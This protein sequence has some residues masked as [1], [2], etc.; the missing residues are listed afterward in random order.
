MSD[1]PEDKSE[2]KR[3]VPRAKRVT[4][5]REFSSVEELVR[6]YVS[7]ISSSGAFIRTADPLPI[8]TKVNLRFTVIAP[9]IETIEGIGRVVRV[10]IAE[11]GTPEGMGVAF[12]EL[13]TYSQRLIE[14]LLTQGHKA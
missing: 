5:N 6:E 10:Q 7:N 3:L 11:D 9:D 4:V 1:E 12:T 2:R 8:G 14:R 13:T